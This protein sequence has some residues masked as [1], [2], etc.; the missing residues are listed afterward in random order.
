MV[1]PVCRSQSWIEAVKWYSSALE[2]SPSDLNDLDE[3][4]VDETDYKIQ[5]KLAIM[6]SQGEWRMYGKLFNAKYQLLVN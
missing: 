5:A 4:A 6:Y 3:S 2:A 1:S